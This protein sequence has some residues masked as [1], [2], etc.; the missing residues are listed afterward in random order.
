M[1]LIDY[2]NVRQN[3]CHHEKVSR[4]HVFNDFDTFLSFPSKIYNKITRD[5]NK[6]FPKDLSRLPLYSDKHC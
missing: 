1:F 4:F 5:V 3:F 6:E 2:K